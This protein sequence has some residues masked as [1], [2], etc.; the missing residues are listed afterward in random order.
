MI[1]SKVYDWLLIT[2]T[3]N[4]GRKSICTYN[5]IVGLVLTFETVAFTISV[6]KKKELQVAASP[7]QWSLSVTIPL[8][9]RG[10]PKQCVFMKTFQGQ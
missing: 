4:L 2:L 5:V 10:Q 6:K 3:V 8:Q 7:L 1:P 9:L